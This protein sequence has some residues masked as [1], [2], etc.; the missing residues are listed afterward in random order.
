MKNREIWFTEPG[1]AELQMQD[2]P[3]TIP[4]GHALVKTEYTAISAGT[5]RDNL[6]GEPH[7]AGAW[8]TETTFPRK[9]GYSGVGRIA[10]LGEGVTDYRVGDRVIIYFG[11]HAE[12]Q[13]LPATREKLIPIPDDGSLSPEEAALYVISCFPAKGVRMTRLEFG[14]AALVMGLGILGLFAVQFCRIAGA[15]P[16]IAADL[17]PARRVLALELGADYALDPSAED[18]K[19]TVMRLT[20]DKG[21]PVC[22]D[23]AGVAPATK[24]ALSVLAWFGRISLLGCT[25]HPDEYDLYSYVHAKGV[26]IVGSNNSARPQVDSIPGNWTAQDDI[27]AIAKL[28]ASGRLRFDKLVNE[29]HSPEEAPE[30]YARLAKR[31]GFPIGVL[32]DWTRLK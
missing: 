7:L 12:Y 10:A 25:R 29:V 20:D 23:V 22:I 27:A 3:D 28:H 15:T 14:E 9:L 26:T 21:V 2:I 18:F 31:V 17:D 24:T 8:I 5:E 19:E 11:S 32:F 30:V 6:M 13:I 16:V 4:A 1:V